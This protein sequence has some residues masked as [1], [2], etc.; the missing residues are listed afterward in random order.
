MN[1]NIVFII[2]GKHQTRAYDV[3]ELLELSEEEI[4]DNEEECDCSLH[5]GNPYCEGDCARFL[6][7]E[8]TGYRYLTDVSGQP[9]LDMTNYKPKEHKPTEQQIEMYRQMKDK[10]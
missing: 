3:M 1:R 10:S 6:D 8:I 5:E 7:S 9:I 2:D 4:I